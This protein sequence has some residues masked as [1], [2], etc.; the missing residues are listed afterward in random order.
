M[1]LEPV[2]GILI[3]LI[4]GIQGTGSVKE[5][6]CVYVMPACNR[7]RAAEEEPFGIALLCG[8]SGKQIFGTLNVTAVDGYT[9]SAV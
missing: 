4:V 8:Y 9:D 2:T 7:N 5:A 6:L 1:C 3:F